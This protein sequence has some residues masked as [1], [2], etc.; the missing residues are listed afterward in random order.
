MDTLFLLTIQ[1]WSISSKSL[2]WLVLVVSGVKTALRSMSLAQLSR[3]ILL[4]LRPG[5]SLELQL[6]RKAQKIKALISDI[7]HYLDG[8]IV[9]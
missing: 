6:L 5:L 7:A 2:R 1:I 3:P 4:V 9:D 8:F